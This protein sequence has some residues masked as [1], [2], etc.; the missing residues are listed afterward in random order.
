MLDAAYGKPKRSNSSTECQ[1]S[2]PPLVGFK[3]RYLMCDT[4]CGVALLVDIDTSKNVMVMYH[5][6]CGFLSTVAIHFHDPDLYVYRR[7]L[8]APSCAGAH[9]RYSR[10]ARRSRQ[11]LRAKLSGTGKRDR[12]S[13]RITGL[14]FV[15]DVA[16]II[17][18]DIFT[19]ICSKLKA[20][21]RRVAQDDR[22]STVALNNLSQQFRTWVD[23]TA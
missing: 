18:A 5:V 1:L 22:M 2:K 19:F 3:F 10:N 20:F 7:Y 14:R 4:D 16:T 11:V 13:H 21:K 23:M 9:R 12:I 6:R 17:H 15:S 8:K